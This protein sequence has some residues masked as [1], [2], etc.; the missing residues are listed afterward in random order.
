[1]ASSC[2]LSL[3][4]G[5]GAGPG[6]K[7]GAI[8]LLGM[9]D[10]EPFTRSEVL[11]PMPADDIAPARASEACLAATVPAQP[12]MGACN[13]KPKHARDRRSFES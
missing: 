3:P 12:S 5:R 7:Q 2:I 4:A 13:T 11:A 9:V 1:M 10:Q 8:A 6:C